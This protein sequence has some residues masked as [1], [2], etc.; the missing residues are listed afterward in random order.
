MRKYYLGD[1][2]RST[3]SKRLESDTNDELIFI[4]VFKTSQKIST[5]MLKH[6]IIFFFAIHRSAVLFCWPRSAAV[7]F[8]SLY[9]FGQTLVLWIK[10][11][12]KWFV[13]VVNSKLNFFQF[14][15]DF[16][17]NS[18][19]MIWSELDGYLKSELFCLDLILRIKYNSKNFLIQ[20][21]FNVFLKKFQLI[22]K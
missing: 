21:H 6:D 1:Y 16:L 12:I 7:L 14:S 17:K 10:L 9:V 19:K 11:T 4:F 15:R 2:L 22:K 18:S 3:D 20:I 8:S 13:I 5:R